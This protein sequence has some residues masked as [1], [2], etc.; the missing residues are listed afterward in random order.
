MLTFVVPDSVRVSARSWAIVL[1]PAELV[2]ATLL[3]DSWAMTE[4]A[5]ASIA[6]RLSSARGVCKRSS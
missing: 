2:L 3:A 5:H 4:R 6:R 1:P